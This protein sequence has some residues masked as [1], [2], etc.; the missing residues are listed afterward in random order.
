MEGSWFKSKFSLERRTSLAWNSFT[1][2][3]KRSQVACNFSDCPLM[4][5]QRYHYFL[6]SHCQVHFTGTL[7]GNSSEISITN[8]SF[9]PGLCY[10]MPHGSQG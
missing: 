10:A 3:G 1:D 7:V 5:L 6:F 2:E 8:V 4:Y 9:K